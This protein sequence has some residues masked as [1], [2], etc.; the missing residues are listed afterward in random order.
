VAI[1]F[2]LAGHAVDN[3]RG[4]VQNVVTDSSARGQIAVRNPSITKATALDANG[5][6]VADLPITKDGGIVKLALPDNAL[7]VCLEGVP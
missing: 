6:P 2:E 4:K 3:S 1:S 7:Y 5:M